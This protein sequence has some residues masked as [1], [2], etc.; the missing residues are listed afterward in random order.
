MSESGRWRRKWK[1]SFT[2]CF[3]CGLAFNFW[4]A[5][6]PSSAAAALGSSWRFRCP[7]CDNRT[8]FYMGD[9]RPQG[10]H[11]TYSDVGWMRNFVLLSPLLGLWAGLIAVVLQGPFPPNPLNYIFPLEL[12]IL[13][14]LAYMLLVAYHFR[15]RVRMERLS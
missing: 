11:P 10:G 4:H 7:G 12:V 1:L 15:T 3:E 8:L 6:R 14:Q 9:I 5:R 2:R 13:C